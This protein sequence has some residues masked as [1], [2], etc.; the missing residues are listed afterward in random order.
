MNRLLITPVLF[1]LASVTSSLLATEPTG[2]DAHEVK[3][4][5]KSDQPTHF[6]QSQLR[7]NS[8]W[9]TWEQTT[10]GWMAIFNEKTGLP[11]RA[12]GKGIPMNGHE[13][14]LNTV[15]TNFNVDI[16]QLSEIH[17]VRAGENGSIHDRFFQGQTVDGYPVLFSSVQSKWKDSKLIMWSADVW[18]DAAVPEG[19]ILSDS[20]ILS[21][22]T[23]GLNLQNQEVEMTGWGLLPGD[24]AEG[25]FRLV[26]KLNVKG[27]HEGLIKNYN[28][29]VDAHSGRVW[30][31]NNTI[32]HHLGKKTVRPMG[33]FNRPSQNT[34]KE[35]V[36]NVELSS[37]LMVVSGQMDA[38]AHPDYPYEDAIELAM[39]N[40][41]LTLNGQTYYSDEAGGFITN[42]SS[43]TMSTVQLKGK[44]SHIYTGG[45]TPSSTITFEDGYN[46]YTAPGNTK[47]ASAYRS[48]NRI[49]DHMK[50]LM[51]D[52]EGLD[53]ALTTNIDVEG[54]CNAFFD[55]TSI[56][57]Y[58]TGGGCNPTSLI[59]DVVFH[60]YGHGI[61]SYYYSSLGSNFMNGAM[62]EAYADYWAMSLGDLAE[63]GKGFYEENND[64][65]RR[66]DADPKVYPQ[67]LVGEV[68]ADGEILAGAWYD[69][70]LL[71]GADWN[72]TDDLFIEAYSGLQAVAAEGNEG[73][74]YTDV[75]L[76]V[77][78]A[79]DNDDDLLNGTPNDAAII[80]GFDIHGITLFSY[81]TV[82]H[83]DVEFANVEETIT[84]EAEVDIVFPFNVY[85]DG[86]Y[87][88]YRTAPNDPWT[89]TLMSQDGEFFTSEINALPAGTVIEYFIKIH[90][91][92]GGVSGVTPMASE[93]QNNS[94]L[95]FYTIVGV[96]PHLINDSDD[97]S[98]LGYWEMDLP[99]DLAT[100]GEWEES[101]PVGS[102]STLGDPSTIVAPNMDHTAGFGGYCFL[103][104]ITPGADAGVG[105][106]D[107]DAG[108][109]T[110]LSPVMDLTE[111]ENPVIS[112]WRWYANAP[113]TGANPASDWW[114]VELSS[115][116]GNSWQYLENTSQQDI[117]WRR[118]AFRIADH[119]PLTDEFQM[120][121]IASDSTTVG[122]Y[123]DG[124]SL[125][126]AALDDI[127]LYD[128]VPN[129]STDDLD[130]FVEMVLSPNPAST[131]A[132]ISNSLISTPIRVYDAKGALVLEQRSSVT[133]N[134][135]LDVQTLKPGIYTVRVRDHHA[136]MKV[137]RLEVIR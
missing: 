37:E 128:V 56:N 77:L 110:L 65:I 8:N 42:E 36:E 72:A 68:H 49:H 80:E 1:F 82:Q 11:H 86:V 111:Y 96:Y 124:G 14:F 115:D 137:L 41:E 25:E 32:A 7:A 91:V 107:V 121:F 61:N 9:S 131:T 81:A 28:T 30:L 40:L 26:R 10:D 6:S 100:T 104:G 48:V 70:H 21:A 23:E 76:D 18:R 108:H 106:N 39:P 101:I 87:L 109:T 57:F 134:T 64:G 83:D 74:A 69:T 126:E 99:S 46:T 63:I 38:L 47:E 120:R 123:L 84:L 67:D 73:Q 55:G 50:M 78:Q 13:D 117:S 135:E 92:F 54:E 116:G 31:R 125:V 62:H 119:V 16:S 85:F 95:P 3:L 118:K 88:S 136:A 29:W 94:N 24:Y 89:E 103:T 79:D 19:I 17:S 2:L 129:S 35:A 98:E 27:K 45:V 114:Q 58:D 53:F 12:W 33:V 66:Y 102:Y 5:F 113:V 71:M 15:L 44:W 52:F 122:E 75:L 132:L 59:A 112:Y 127:I 130:A 93:L 133:G 43:A 90:D 60:E 97:Y 20:E 105:E 22:A 34:E 4:Q 51:P